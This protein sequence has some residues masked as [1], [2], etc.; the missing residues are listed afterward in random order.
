MLKGSSVKDH[1][2]SY[3][4]DECK[5]KVDD[6]LNSDD[7]AAILIINDHLKMNECFF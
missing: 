4:I 3:E 1:L 2:E 6:F 7:P 5:K